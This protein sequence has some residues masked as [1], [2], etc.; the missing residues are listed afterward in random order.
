MSSWGQ[1]HFRQ[2]KVK[3]KNDKSHWESRCKACIARR[4]REL[5]DADEAEVIAGL[6]EYVRSPTELDTQAEEDVPPVSGKLERWLSHLSRCDSVP[7]ELQALAKA[8]SKKENANGPGIRL[9]RVQ[10]AARAATILPSPH[11]RL[12]LN[13]P[14]LS[15]HHAPPSSILNARMTLDVPH[16]ICEP[17]ASSLRYGVMWEPPKQEEFA[18]DLCKL[19]VA[20]NISWNSAA[21]PQL[22]LFFSK[23]VP[24]AKIPDRRVLSGRVLDSLALQAETG[25][26][27]IVT[28]RLGTGQCDGWKSGAKAAII[29]TSVTVDIQLYMIA[30]HDVSPE[31]KTAD[32]LLQIVL[33]DME[34]C[35][36]LGII[37]I[38]YCTDDGGDA[39][40]MRVRLKRVKPKLLIPPCWGHQVNLI[41]AEVLE[42]DVPCMLSIDDGLNIVKWFTNH[43]R[44]IGLL[45]EEQKLTERFEKTHRLLQLI[46]P[47]ISRWIYHFLAVRRILTLSPPM[48]TLHF[49]HHDKLIECAGPKRDARAKA[50][51][52]L[53]PIEDPQFWKNL[54]EVK[55]LLEP[56]AIVAKCMQVPD[57]GLD[58]VLLM[59]GNLYRIYGS[60]EINS[61]IRSCVR[62][63]LEKRWLAMEREVFI[64]AVYLSPYIRGSAF[65]PK[66]PALKVISLYNV[67]KRLFQGPAGIFLKVYETQMKLLYEHENKRVNVAKVWEQLDTGEA[68]GRNGLVKLAIW[69]L[70]IIANSAGS[71]RGYSKFGLFLT[72]LRSQLSIQ[73][74][75]KMMTVDMDLKRQHEE[76]GLTTDR[77]KRKFVHFAEH[78]VMILPTAGMCRLTKKR[79][80]MKKPCQLFIHSPTTLKELFQYPTDNTESLENG[81]GFHWQGGVKDLQDEMELYDLLMEEFDL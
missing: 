35:E 44:A 16:A 55:I 31:R 36:E 21:N 50:E 26:K 59:L 80:T 64:L 7:P 3:Y 65:S 32:N 56:L 45:N 73:K 48:C 51:K 9:S 53:A 29:T 61:R 38:A 11:P 75:R 4:V 25:M 71:E 47:V 22:N 12:T 1:E 10:D 66:N 78:S 63:S 62:K 19:F 14:G 37:M 28:G 54:A 34:Y 15:R 6:R 42:L 40:G 24:E 2:G 30:A 70:S 5:R 72:K 77:I 39:R 58:Q 46:F 33:E 57:A 79:R 60:P 20:C 67:A 76:L 13:G 27:S 41:V 8:A 49:N 69:I 81:L 43:S 18:Q 68:N 17:Q 23:Y 74:V 52:I